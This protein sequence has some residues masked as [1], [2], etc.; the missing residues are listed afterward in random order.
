MDIYADVGPRASCKLDSNGFVGESG[1]VELS[2]DDIQV[3]TEGRIEA[4]AE[5]QACK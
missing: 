5:P 2:G 3:P 1:A 4:K